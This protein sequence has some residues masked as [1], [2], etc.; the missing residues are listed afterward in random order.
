M[1]RTMND[2]LTEVRQHN[3]YTGSQLHEVAK[4]GADTGWSGWSG[5]TATDEY[6]VNIGQHIATFARSD[7]LEDWDSF[8]NLLAWWALETTANYAVMQ[9]EGQ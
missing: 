1:E 4:Y 2:L 9:T 5:W 8:R 6:G 7:M 3:D